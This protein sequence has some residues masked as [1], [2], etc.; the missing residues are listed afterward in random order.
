MLWVLLAR[1]PRGGGGGAEG[2]VKDCVVDTGC[3]ETIIGMSV[4]E[5][6]CVADPH[7]V[8]AG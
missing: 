6:M 2:T 8:S 4:G 5:R 7:L 3:Q 1:V